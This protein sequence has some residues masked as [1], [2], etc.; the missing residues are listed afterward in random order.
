MSAVLASG[1]AEL[2]TDAE[3]F[4]DARDDLVVEVQVAPI[5]DVGDSAAA[6]IFNGA[7]TMIIHV[8]GEA[9]GHVLD[10]AEAIMHRRGADL[11]ARR[12]EG[13]MLGG[14]G[15]IANTSN[16]DDGD[17]DFFRDAGEK[18]KGDGFHGGAAI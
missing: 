12:A 7:E 15:P 10:D 5:H 14:V 16:A 2:A 18:M 17:F 1:V 3:I 6:E 11:N 13:D 8:G 9:V 4:V